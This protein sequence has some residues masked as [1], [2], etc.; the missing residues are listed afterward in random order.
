MK[1]NQK[2]YTDVHDVDEDQA[3]LTYHGG[4][5]HSGDWAGIADRYMSSTSSLSIVASRW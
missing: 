3:T 4:L 2:Y 5:W 1:Y